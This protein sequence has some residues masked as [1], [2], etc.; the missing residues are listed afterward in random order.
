MEQPGVAQKA[1]AC[2]EERGNHGD[3]HC[4]SYKENEETESDLHV[5]HNPHYVDAGQRRRWSYNSTT[6]FAE[7]K[8]T[9]D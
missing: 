7:G 6:C 8:I 3:R 9:V 4:G 2:S 5:C 1:R